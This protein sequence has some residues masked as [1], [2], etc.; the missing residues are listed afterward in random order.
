M[1]NGGVLLKL[2][3]EVAYACASRYAGCYV[4][5]TI[6]GSVCSSRL[7]TSARWSLSRRVNHVGRTSMEVGIKV[8]AE[9]I[10]ER[11]GATHQV[12]TSPWWPMTR[13]V[14]WR[15]RR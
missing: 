2:L 4:G 3:D 8:V 7:S 1:Y 9:N 13:Q 14:P 10:L 11:T 5:N 15:C 6:G 12:A